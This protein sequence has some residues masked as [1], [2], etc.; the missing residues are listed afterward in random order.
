MS[1]ITVGIDT[2]RVYKKANPPGGFCTDLFGN[3]GQQAIGYASSEA[4]DNLRNQY[5]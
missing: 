5:R 4:K 2:D 3:N 1:F